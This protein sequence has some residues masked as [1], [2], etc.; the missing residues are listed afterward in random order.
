MNLERAIAAR[1]PDWA[2]RD[3][4][5]LRYVLQHGPRHRVWARRWLLWPCMVIITLGLAAVSE[6]IAN[7]GAPLGLQHPAASTWFAPLYIATVILQLVS[8]LLALILPSALIL[9]ERQRSRW[10]ALKVTPFGGA[11][12]L[13]ARWAAVFYELRGPLLL[14]VIL[15]VVLAAHML[16]DLTA[17]QGYQLDLYL[18]GAVPQVSPEAAIFSLAAFMTFALLWLLVMVG[19]NAAFGLLIAALVRGRTAALLARFAALAG[20]MTMF[21]LAMSGGGRVVN[22]APGSPALDTLDNT[23]R[24]IRLLAL[25]TLGDQGLRFMDL[26]TLLQAWVDVRYGVWLSVVWLGVMLAAIA[27]TQGVMTGAARWASRPEGG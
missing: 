10:D 13:R 19:L 24:W 17:H 8:I 6:V 7:R 15:R 18:A 14:L 3:H 25:G 16:A 9:G 4:P 20:E 2:R 1:L 12:V 5:A 21:M 22:H 23:S 11:L 26:E 27:L